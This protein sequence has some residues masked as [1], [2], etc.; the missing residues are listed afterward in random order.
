M[1]GRAARNHSKRRELN[2]HASRR[3]KPLDS[4]LSTFG[5]QVQKEEGGS[6]CN[7]CLAMLKTA[8]VATGRL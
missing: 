2:H 3:G 4:H 1:A 8:S 5:G 7:Q 6:Q